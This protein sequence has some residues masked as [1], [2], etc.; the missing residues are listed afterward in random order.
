MLWGPGLWNYDMSLQKYFSITESKRLQLRGDFLD[1]FN[2]MNL[3]NPSATIADVADGGTAQPL[4]GRIT[5][6]SGSRIIQLGLKF[7]F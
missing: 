1:A 3:G 7:M 5:G 4:A 6:G 2:H